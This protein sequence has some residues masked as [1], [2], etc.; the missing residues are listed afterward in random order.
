MHLFPSRPQEISS[1]HSSCFSVCLKS[2]PLDTTVVGCHNV[3]DR[4]S[5]SVGHL[6]FT[7]NTVDQSYVA[8]SNFL[9]SSR[10]LVALKK[11][12][13]LWRNV[14]T[15]ADSNAVNKRDIIMFCFILDL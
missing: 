11:S 15:E 9:G 3:C 8:R 1:G 7:F 5:M 2:K 10:L 4:L 14:L 6:P 12:L 13:S